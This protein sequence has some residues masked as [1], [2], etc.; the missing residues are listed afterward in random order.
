MRAWI[1]PGPN[2]I[3]SSSVASLNNLVTKLQRKPIM[4]EAIVIINNTHWPAYRKPAGTLV[5]L[6]LCDPANHDADPR[7]IFRP[8]ALRELGAPTPLIEAAA[9]SKPQGLVLLND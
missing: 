4:H 5:D 9:Q 3:N 2:S 7:L 8:D 6:R 1:E